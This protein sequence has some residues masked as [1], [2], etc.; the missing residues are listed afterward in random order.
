MGAAAKPR[1]AVVFL[2]ILALG[3]SLD[4]P[5]QDVLDAVYDEYEPLPYEQNPPVAK[6]ITPLPAATTQDAPNFLH[7][8]PDSPSRL[9]SGGTDAHRPAKI[10]DQSILLFVLLC[11]MLC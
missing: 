9:F 7:Q 2:M 4:L 11:I 1:C 3:V 10:R 5:A 8:K 6:V